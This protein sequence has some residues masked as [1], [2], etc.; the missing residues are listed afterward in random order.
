MLLKMQ[1]FVEFNPTEKLNKGTVS[2]K[3][4]MENLKPFTKF[5]DTYS[6]EKYNGGTKFR[7]GD[8]LVARITPC[9]EN[10][11]TSYVDILDNNEVAFGSSEYIVM[12][13]K[14]N[15][16]DE[17]YLYYLS[18]SPKI[19][20][21]AIKSMVGSSGR[22]R[23]QTNVLKDTVVDLPDLDIQKKVSTVLA[24]I[25]NKIRLNNEINDNLYC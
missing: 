12:R 22:Q 3:I 21:I 10:G 17:N 5:I 9:L 23:V 13:A 24:S 2:K 15:I 14:N 11:K 4:P 25:D 18:T 7:N 20:E 8:T 19:R 6:I 1:D 16:C